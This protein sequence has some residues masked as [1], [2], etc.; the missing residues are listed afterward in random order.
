MIALPILS[1]VSGFSSSDFMAAQ[2]NHNAILQIHLVILS[3]LLAILSFFGYNEI[4][5]GAER[6]AK[7]GV[8]VALN[9]LVPKLVKEQIEKLG[10]ERISQMLVDIKT[11]TPPN[12]E[13]KMLSDEF[14]A[15]EILSGL[16]E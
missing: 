15:E 8:E 1:S 5:K 3:I 4:K 13:E 2:A 14:R 10:P 7:E 6:T 16:E 9:E 12:K 11:A